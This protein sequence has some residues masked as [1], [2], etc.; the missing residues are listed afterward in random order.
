[1][2]SFFWC[3]FISISAQVLLNVMHLCRI[4]GYQKHQGISRLW[5][6]SR[7]GPRQ[8]HPAGHGCVH[9]VDRHEM[10]RSWLWPS[11]WLASLYGTDFWFTAELPLLSGPAGCFPCSDRGTQGQ[12][13]GKQAGSIQQRPKKHVWEEKTGLCELRCWKDGEKLWWVLYSGSV[14]PSMQFF[15]HWRSDRL[16]RI[17]K[18]R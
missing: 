14:P 11:W 9:C 18:H 5:S 8:G 16:D 12:S 7:S 3:C 15:L 2:A 1:M 10:A 4:I 17:T 6:T 13:I